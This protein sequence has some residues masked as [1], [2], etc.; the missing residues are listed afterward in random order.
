[1]KTMREPC[2]TYDRRDFLRV[3]G[4]AAEAGLSWP[5]TIVLRCLSMHSRSASGQWQGMP[6]AESLAW[7][8]P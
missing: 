4:P 3:L 2:L 7:Y 6:T 1:M 5:L 8:P